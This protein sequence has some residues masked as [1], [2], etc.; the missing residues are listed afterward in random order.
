MRKDFRVN[1]ISMPDLRAPINPYG[2]RASHET[3]A[4]NPAPS[5]P[6]AL[7]SETQS[8]EMLSPEIAPKAPFQKGAEG[9]GMQ[10]ALRQW[11]KTVSQQLEGDARSLFL[12]ISSQ[13]NA[14]GYVDE[15][16]SA[17]LKQAGA[18]CGYIKGTLRY[19][20]R[21]GLIARRGARRLWAG[22]LAPPLRSG[23]AVE[24]KIVGEQRQRILARDGYSCVACGCTKRLAIDHVVAWSAGGS[25][26]DNNLQVLCG[27]CNS[28][29][30]DRTQEDF[31]ALCIKAGLVINRRAA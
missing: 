19:L 26:D 18:R 16:P 6:R 11:S 28:R 17:L 24:A 23:S 14:A 9:E 8:G 3:G 29:K 1:A 20:E 13:F 5:E 22:P 4:S 2:E 21:R 25:N 30:R 12:A 7:S 10:A 27:A 15:T 31:E